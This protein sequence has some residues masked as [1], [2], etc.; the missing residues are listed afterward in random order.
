ME[1]IQEREYFIMKSIQVAKI[2]LSVN[3]GRL[4]QH[5]D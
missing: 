4:S 1:S 2:I 5:L 3:N